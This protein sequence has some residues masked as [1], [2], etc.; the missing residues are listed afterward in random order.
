VDFVEN[1]SGH[2]EGAGD[3]VPGLQWKA[4]RKAGHAA[5]NLIVGSD[6]NLFAE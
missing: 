6:D 5:N 2:Q 3:G 4:Q 1:Q